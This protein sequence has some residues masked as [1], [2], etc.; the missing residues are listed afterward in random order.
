MSVCLEQIPENTVSAMRSSGPR[1]R[2]CLAEV[3]AFQS[4]LG[5]F[6]SC[7]SCLESRLA[8]VRR[9]EPASGW[10]SLLHSNMSPPKAESPFGI[11]FL[12]VI[13]AC[14]NGNTLS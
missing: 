9:E 4:W 2:N 6:R 11:Q 13:S 14:S 3:V 12:S 5:A 7:V 8:S 10:S 1:E